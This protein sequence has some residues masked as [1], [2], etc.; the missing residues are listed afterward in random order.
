MCVFRLQAKLILSLLF[1]LT[2]LCS[3]AHQYLLKL[4]NGDQV[5]SLSKPKAQGPNY[6][7]TDQDG[8]EHLIPKSRVVKIETGTAASE[9]APPGPKPEPPAKPKK[10]KHWYFLW[11]A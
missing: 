9:E 11:L 3:C 4:S 5:V 7:F 1:G 10:P 6:R 2:L 8:V